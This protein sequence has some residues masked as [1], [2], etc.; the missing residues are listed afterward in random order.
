MVSRNESSDSGGGDA[1]SAA[2]LGMP[3]LRQRTVRPELLDQLPFDHPAVSA[4]RRDMLWLNHLLGN[5]RWF[6][7]VL[8]PVA[9]G[10]RIVE[11]AGGDGSLFAYLDR[12]LGL[13][14]RHIRYTIIDLAP[15]PPS[16]PSHLEWISTDLLR[17]SG[18]DQY[19]IILG[20]HILHQFSDADLQ[21]FARSWDPIPAWYFCE[22]WRLPLFWW[23]F[24]LGCVPWLCEVSR[25]DG[26][27]SI[28]AGFRG[29]ELLKW[30][31]PGGTD[32]RRTRLRGSVRGAQ[33]LISQRINEID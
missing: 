15:P 29:T 30:L 16:K 13:R 2:R 32:R 33:R 27:V 8:G 10:T 20:N 22:P 24:R 14:E 31:Q 11:I 21:G 26:R 9:P 7:G 1:G 5:F 12:A 19:D 25:H 4:N 18:W 6:A 3:D 17:Y 28:E 23:A